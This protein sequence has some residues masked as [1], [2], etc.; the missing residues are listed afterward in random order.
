MKAFNKGVILS[1]KIVSAKTVGCCAAMIS[2]NRKTFL[3]PTFKGRKWCESW[4]E[5]HKLKVEHG[6]AAT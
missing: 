5:V 3:P 1:V 6:N 2:K 4:L